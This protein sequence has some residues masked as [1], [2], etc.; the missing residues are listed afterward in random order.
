MNDN[1]NLNFNKYTSL[2]NSVTNNNT[3]NANLNDSID[4]DKYVDSTTSNNNGSNSDQLNV[5]FSNKGPTSSRI[6]YD[7]LRLCQ[8]TGFNEAKI[9]NFTNSFLKFLLNLNLI[10]II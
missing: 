3:N 1:L 6:K 8:I 10:I 7:S 4:A 9:Y 5:N 2:N